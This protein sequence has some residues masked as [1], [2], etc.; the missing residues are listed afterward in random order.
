MAP[1]EAGQWLEARAAFES[2]GDSRAAAVDRAV[3]AFSEAKNA[4]AAALEITADAQGELEMQP[5]VGL[6]AAAMLLA[7]L[8]G[9]FLSR[10]IARAAGQVATAATGLAVGDL[11][12]Q[13]TVHSGDELGQMADA[14]RSMIAYQQ[15]MADVARAMAMGDLTQDV[16]PK[17]AADVLGIA[18]GHM[19]ANLRTFVS[20]LQ[21][22]AATL[23]AQ[24]QL[25]ELASDAILVIDFETRAIQF[26]SHGAEEVYGWTR[27][28]ALTDARRLARDAVSG[29]QISSYRRTVPRWPLGGRARPNPT[30]RRPAGRRQSPGRPARSRWHARRGAA[31]QH[32]H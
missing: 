20:D 30:R 9:Y 7:L 12:Q 29:V 26:W 22:Q 31:D 4:A 11:D 17:G 19:T 28:E 8:I 18:F 24:A 3:V 32:Q 14:V 5:V 27:A 2:E 13:V 10:E 21:Q 6:T 25:L 15:E 16:T 23:S 1:L